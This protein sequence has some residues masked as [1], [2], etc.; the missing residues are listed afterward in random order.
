MRIRSEKMLLTVALGIAALLA[1]PTKAE[2]LRLA[3]STPDMNRGDPFARYLGGTL[4]AAIFDGLTQIALTG[5]IQPAL[6]LSWTAVSNTEWI[7]RLRPDAKFSNGRAVT[8]QSVVAVLDYLRSPEAQRHWTASELASINHADAIDDLTLK[9]ITKEP[10]PLLPRRLS[11]MTVPDMLAWSEMGEVAF[12]E[13]PVGTGPYNV[14]SWGPGGSDITLNAAPTAWRKPQTFTSIEMKVVTD[15]TRRVQ[16]LLSGE[17]QLAVNLDPDAL[18]PLKQ[19]GLK[20][21][22]V[23]NPIVVAV[24]LK[25]ADAFGSPLLDV[26]VRRAL[27]HAVNTSAISLQILHG[28]M[29]PASQGVTEGTVGHNPA[30]TRYE[31]DPTKARALLSEAGYPKGFAMTMGVWT[32]QVPGDAMM[33]Q[34]VAQDL[35][36]VGVKV[37]LRIL[38]YQEFSR[39]M[40][41]SD[42]KGI[43]AL[44]LVWTSR[45]ML[46]ALPTL[47]QYSCDRKPSSFFCDRDL[48]RAIDDVRFEMDPDV[49]TK[50]LQSAMATAV[51]AAPSIFLVNYADVVAMQPAMNGYEVRSDG[52][53]FEKM[54]IAADSTPPR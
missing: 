48:D 11:V 30:I 28:L 17:V 10:D 51:A 25:T 1:S 29:Q 8:A 20:T 22:I 15:A 45:N 44:S 3:I 37:E 47:E 34:Q 33:F 24:G 50:R 54:T 42:W 31:Y 6:A 2:T 9:L 16:A 41:A 38:P 27:N 23:P 7:I 18:D 32:G 4:K 36:N 5:E 52:I 14:A 40:T 35:A 26:R 13:N 19:A 46:D 12:A 49:R 53:L 43:E 39:R 21:L